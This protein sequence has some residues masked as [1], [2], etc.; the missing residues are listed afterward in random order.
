MLQQRISRNLI[1]RQQ[2]Y[3]AR[4]RITIKWLDNNYCIVNGRNCIQFCNNDYLGISKH[5]L[6]KE[7]AITAVNEFGVGSTA[8][9]LIAGF[10]D[11]TQQLEQEFAEFLGQKRALIFS[12]GYMANLALM[13]A[14]TTKEDI[15]FA[16]KLNHAS[17][18]DA[19]RLSY[20]W[21]QRYQHNNL[22]QLERFLETKKSTHRFI[23]SDSVFSMTG[24][25]ANIHALW[26]LAKMH[27]ATLVLDDSHGIGVLGKKGNGIAEIFFTE[28]NKPI[29][30]AGLGKAFGCGGGVIA[31]DIDEI[32]TIVQTGRNYIYSTAISPI[33]V[34]A[35]RAALKIIQE[36]VWRRDHLK[37][38]IQVFQTQA[39]LLNLPVTP[40]V[41]AIQPIVVGDARKAKELE[42]F[43]LSKNIFVRAIRP[44]SVPNQQ[45]L[46]RI[47][48]T[49]THTIDQ[50]WQLLEALQQ[51]LKRDV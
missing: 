9:P 15:I 34:L 6:I 40:S 1:K 36:E 8:S 43:L 11:Q 21:H 25:M 4:E 35:L 47:V 41:T 44:P 7:A 18:I 14:L 2:Q 24:E 17:L 51:G 30:T 10:S 22:M 3:L 27:Q 32:E 5:P 13:S 49:A 28:K 48:L 39:K 29:Y 23:I 31:G 42:Q 37:M 12:S 33:L 46:L 38:L 26:N 19:C 20:A 16:D 45:S 50:V